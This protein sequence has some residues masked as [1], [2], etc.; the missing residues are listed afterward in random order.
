M[1]PPS[2]PWGRGWVAAGVFFSRGGPGEGVKAVPS[3]AN[4]TQCI[5]V[6]PT[7][8]LL[9]RFSAVGRDKL[10]VFNTGIIKFRNSDE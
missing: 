6:S 9:A 10:S 4:L 7:S 8:T 5:H 2:P 1:R 3:H